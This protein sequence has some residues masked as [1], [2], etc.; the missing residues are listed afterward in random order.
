VVE[1]ILCGAKEHLALRGIL[2][3]EV[4]NSAEALVVSAQL[5]TPYQ[6]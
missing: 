6:T 3:V 5:T 1:R 4:G 2:V